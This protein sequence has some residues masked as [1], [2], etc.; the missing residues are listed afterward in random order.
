MKT[1]RQT[2]LI[3]IMELIGCVEILCVFYN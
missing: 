2:Y 1:E 3:Y